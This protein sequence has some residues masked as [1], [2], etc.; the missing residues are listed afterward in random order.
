V[1]GFNGGF[2]LIQ[3][4]AVETNGWHRHSNLFTTAHK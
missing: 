2:R 1:A 3:V 4:K